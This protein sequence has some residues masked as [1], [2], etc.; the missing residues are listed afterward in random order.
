MEEILRAVSTLVFVSFAALS[1]KL[2]ILI[3]H[4]IPLL[5]NG[6]DDVFLI[7]HLMGLLW[8]P[9]FSGHGEH[10]ISIVSTNVTGRGE[11]RPSNIYGEFECAKVC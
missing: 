9:W 5:W 8:I 1:H 6:P 7:H 10:V 2:W 11:A 4:S 3:L